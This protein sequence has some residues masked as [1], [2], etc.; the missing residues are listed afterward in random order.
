MNKREIRE[1]T[2]YR[3]LYN[4]VA[5]L[6]IMM[7]LLKK[8]KDNAEKKQKQ[9]I[10][11]GAYT[12]H[13]CSRESCGDNRR[14]MYKYSCICWLIT[15]NYEIKCLELRLR[16]NSKSSSILYSLFMIKATLIMTYG[17]YKTFIARFIKERSSGLL[18][19]SNQKYFDIN[20]LS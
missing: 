10:L 2:I 13:D 19:A 15:V 3:K 17:Y 12:T 16:N 14:Y 18:Y 20:H 1:I 11:I 5:I 7:N 9:E 8:I 6:H 4:T